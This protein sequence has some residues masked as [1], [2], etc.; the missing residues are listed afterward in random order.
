MAAFGGVSVT[1]IFLEFEHFLETAFNELEVDPEMFCSLTA[2][3][4]EC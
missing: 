3:D 2:S 1:Y 4:R